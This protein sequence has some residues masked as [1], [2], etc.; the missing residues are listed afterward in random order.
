MPQ[1]FRG[2]QQNEDSNSESDSIATPELTD[3]CL[4]PDPDP[5]A[6]PQYRKGDLELSL[7]SDKL[8]NTSLH[9]L[10][11]PPS[12]GNKLNNAKPSRDLRGAGADDSDTFL[13][14][15]RALFGPK[16]S[17]ATQQEIPELVD[18][19]SALESVEPAPA[20]LLAEAG[21][22]DHAPAP[23]SDLIAT[24]IPASKS[25]TPSTLRPV[26]SIPLDPSASP[27]TEAKHR[28]APLPPSR[29]LDLAQFSQHLGAVCLVVGSVPRVWDRRRQRRGYTFTECDGLPQRH[30]GTILAVARC[31][32]TRQ[33]NLKSRDYSSGFVARAQSTSQS[34]FSPAIA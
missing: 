29:G 28:S 21:A 6:D 11:I 24:S 26:V 32:R 5:I 19:A 15:A 20:A 23:M 8:L 13:R 27:G 12:R 22:E 25:F 33:L 34:D 30:A 10:A 7:P 16:H 3:R 14:K 9:P 18:S 2:D 31:A 4:S 1:S 17:D